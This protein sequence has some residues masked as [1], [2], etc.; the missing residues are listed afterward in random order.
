MCKGTLQ[1]VSITVLLLILAGLSSCVPSPP[2]IESITPTSGTIGTEIL[3]RGSGFT[4][5]NNDIAF[6]HP[7]I[8]FHGS[9]TAYLN[10]ISSPD[11]KTLRFTL[12]DVLGACAFSQMK[13]YEACP[14]VGIWVPIGPITIAVV[15]R[16]GMSNGVIFER[17]KSEIELAQEIIYQSPAY[18][19]LI[20][21]LD[22]IV[23]RT[24][25][26]VSVG[27]RKC[28]E[29]ICI[30]VWIEKDVPELSRK[31]PAQIEGFE[32]RIERW[33]H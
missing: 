4:P 13:L 5:D 22:E 32:V 33:G 31:I 14:D 21:I 3:I 10:H 20:E 2:V 28:E 19:E 25:G 1:A 24:G 30:M 11:G 16:N 18:R 23:R 17:I 26:F 9:N 15:N 8:N 29:K 27:I 12:P 6:T 7:D